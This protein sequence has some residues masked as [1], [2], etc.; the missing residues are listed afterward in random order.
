MR[1]PDISGYLVIGVVLAIAAAAMA[2]ACKVNRYL[3]LLLAARFY[4]WMPTPGHLALLFAP[5]LLL[6]CGGL[7]TAVTRRRPRT[8]QRDTYIGP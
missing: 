7:L 4:P 6:A 1:S 3:L 8:A 5:P 2:L